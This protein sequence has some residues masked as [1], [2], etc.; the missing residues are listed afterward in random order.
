MVFRRSVGASWA[1]E[2]ARQRTG[3]SSRR[4]NLRAI[5]VWIRPLG[6]CSRYLRASR[7]EH[8]RRDLTGAVRLRST[9]DR[10]ALRL[11]GSE[12]LGV[13][14]TNSVYAPD[15]TTIDLCT[16]TADR[17]VSMKAHLRID[18]A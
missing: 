13:D 1:S 4:P 8:S 11:Y 10:Q 16:P 7:H 3:D 2:R 15:P 17:L 18:V 5:I 14:P 12:S 6:L 9:T